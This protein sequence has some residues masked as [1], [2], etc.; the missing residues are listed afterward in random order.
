MNGRFP[1]DQLLE[2]QTDL[3]GIQTGKC[4]NAYRGIF[5]GLSHHTVQLNKDHILGNFACTQDGVV[6]DI[7]AIGEC[8][9]SRRVPISAMVTERVIAVFKTGGKNMTIVKYISTSLIH[10]PGPQRYLS[11]KIK[12]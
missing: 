7:Q 3:G 9:G 5:F 2:N 11:C 12:V 1:K 4:A 8:L 6:P 10:S